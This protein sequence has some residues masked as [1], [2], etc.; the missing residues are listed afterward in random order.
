MKQ[1][2][3]A[4]EIKA[5]HEGD[6]NHMAQTHLPGNITAVHLYKRSTKETFTFLV[7]DLGKSTEKLAKGDIT[8]PQIQG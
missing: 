8:W 7:K 3:P 5:L 2:K 1:I 6:F 4:R